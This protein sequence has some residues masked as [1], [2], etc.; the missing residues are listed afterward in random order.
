MWWFIVIKVSSSLALLA[1]LEDVQLNEGRR[2]SKRWK[3]DSSE[4]FSCKSFFKFLLDSP[5]HPSFSPSKTVWE[6]KVPTKVKILG[7]LVAHKR[8]NTCDLI[9][10]RRPNCYLSPSWCILCKRNEENADH[11]FVHCPVALKL[12]YYLFKEAGV[13]WVIPEGCFSLLSEGFVGFGIGNKAKVLWGCCRM[14]I[15]W[16]IWLER[17]RRIFDNFK[18]VGVEELWERVRFWSSLWASITPEFRDILFSSILLD[19][20]AVL[21]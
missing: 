5:E 2:D 21:G 10:R 8:V 11:L 6:A 4:V 18:G 13:S 20:R 9:Q 14:A 3:L 15:L 17:N 19:W 1:L 16:V 12:W 7:W